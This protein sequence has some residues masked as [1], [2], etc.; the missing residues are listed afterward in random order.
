MQQVIEV[1]KSY[2]KEKLLTIVDIGTGS[3]VIAITLALELSHAQ[4]YATDISQEAL[5]VAEIN[6]KQLQADVHFLHGDY[7]QPLIDQGIYAWI[8]VYNQSFILKI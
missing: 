8:I 7:L 2:P 1:T 5:Q 4:I 6:A 3:G